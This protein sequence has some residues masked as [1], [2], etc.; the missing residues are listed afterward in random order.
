[1]A[2]AASLPGALFQAWQ[3]RRQAWPQIAAVLAFGLVIA[4]LV[5]IWPFGGNFRGLMRILM[6]TAAVN[7]HWAADPSPGFI[8]SPKKI[9]AF[10]S[11]FIIPLL[12]IAAARYTR[13]RYGDK[14]RN[15]AN[16]AGRFT[17]AFVLIYTVCSISYAFARM[18]G[19]VY[20]RSYQVAMT[21]A[22]VLALAIGRF[23]RPGQARTV[24]L[25]ILLLLALSM[26]WHIIKPSHLWKGGAE[27]WPTFAA[28]AD[29]RDFGLP[30]LG[31]GRFSER[32]LTEEAAVRRALDRV[33]A[34]DETFLDLTME[35][36]HYFTSERKLWTEY[37]VYYVY[38]GDKPQKRALEVIARKRI[39]VSLLDSSM[40]FDNSPVNLRG[41]YLYRYAL[42]TG[43]PW[44]I[45]PTKTILMPAEYFKRIGSNPPGTLESLH[46][47][48]KQFPDL[49]FEYLPSVWGRGFTKWRNILTE[50]LNWDNQLDNSVS[51]H[52]TFLPP[53]GLRGKDGGL[54]LIDIDLQSSAQA[55]LEITWHNADWPDE[56]NKITFTAR[57]GLNLIP[58]D[59]APRWL[60]AD[61]I[62]TVTLATQ[63]TPFAIRT[64]RLLQRDQFTFAAP[65]EPGA[66]K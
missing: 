57:N 9:L 47:L 62:T 4:G 44:E 2:V 36:L 53:Q 45:S 49:D 20:A 60:L 21:L 41:Y 65:A 19:I 7:S 32:F 29:G 18:D 42:L 11:F 17:M 8:T 54:L 63:D 15:A 39:Y 1:V 23:C 30:N 52:H 22:G 6:E 25:L 27:P 50:I 14:D 35:G 40:V 37:P 61:T 66:S 28:V 16:T 13:G 64:I 55:P 51:I 3:L 31:Q 24:L 10:L 38:P 12:A 46:L 56:T 43:L 58:L 59:A 34:P 48:D 33:L 5:F 26:P